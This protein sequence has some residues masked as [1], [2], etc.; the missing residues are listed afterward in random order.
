MMGILRPVLQED[1]KALRTFNSSLQEVLTARIIQ[2][3]IPSLDEEARNRLREK[4]HD[5]V[6][7]ST[8]E[9]FHELMTSRAARVGRCSPATESLIAVASPEQHEVLPSTSTPAEIFWPPLPSTLQLVSSTG[10]ERQLWS[11]PGNLIH[12]GT[13]ELPEDFELSRLMGLVEAIDDDTF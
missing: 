9:V 11:K 3:I 1:F 5:V 6:I 13:E 8:Q 2:E 4:I 12:L 10:E 7:S